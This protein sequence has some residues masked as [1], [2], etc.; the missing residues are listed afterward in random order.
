MWIL[1]KNDYSI[2]KLKITFNCL[3]DVMYWA[4]NSHMIM[5]CVNFKVTIENYCN[6]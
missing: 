2:T 6:F 5:S 4:Y 3:E 1:R